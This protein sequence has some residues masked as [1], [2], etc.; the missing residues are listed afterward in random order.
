MV[1]GR[2][3]VE[4]GSFSLPEFL[5]SAFDAGEKFVDLGVGDDE[6]RGDC[7]EVANASDDRAFVANVCGS[8]DA[9]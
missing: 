9:K 3:F 1:I 5:Q 7:N 2:I 8:G 4:K 6:W